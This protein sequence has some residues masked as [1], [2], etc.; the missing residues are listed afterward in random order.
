MDKKELLEAVERKIEAET[1]RMGC[2]IPFVARDGR[3]EDKGEEDIAWWTN[4]FWPGI[5][6][7]MYRDTGKQVFRDT[8]DRVEDRLDRAMDE[9]LGIHHDV[10]FMWHLSSSANFGMT[11]S[12]RSYARALHAATVLAGRY[13]PDTGFIRCWNEGLEGYLI[14]DSMMNICLLYWASEQTG[15]PR[16]RA[17]AV[18]HADK[19]L[20][21]HMLDDGHVRHIVVLDQDDGSV[22]SIP[23][24]QGYAPDSA[25]TRG[26]AWGLYGYA[27]SYL[28]TE[29]ARYLE[30]AKRIA[31]FFIRHAERTGWVPRVDFLAPAEPAWDDTTAA[32]CAACGMLQIAEA[33]T[34]EE[35]RHYASAAEQIVTKSCEKWADL[36]PGTDGILDGGSGSY[37][38]KRHEEKIIYGDFFLLDALLRMNGRTCNLW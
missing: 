25:W 33:C 10:G 21:T 6:W 34:G 15:D 13:N 27:L 12:K 23:A 11:G 5:M 16:F 9:F 22:R 32:A 7:L 31:D 14:I 26:Q 37:S 2:K 3:Y 35:K 1:L 18:H 19:I 36:D 20:E 38:A 24:G 17:I 29:N 30:A 4:G 28:H 8:A